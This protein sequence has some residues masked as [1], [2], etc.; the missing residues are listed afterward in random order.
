MPCAHLV[1]WQDCDARVI[2]ELYR[3]GPQYV[4]DLRDRPYFRNEFICPLRE[5]AGAH[6]SCVRRVVARNIVKLCC[7]A[8]AGATAYRASA[9]PRA[10]GGIWDRDAA[11]RRAVA[12]KLYVRD[13]ASGCLGGCSRKTISEN[14]ICALQFRSTAGPGD[15][16]SAV[17]QFAA[18]SSISAATR[19]NASRAS[20]RLP[21]MSRSVGKIVLSRCAVLHTGRAEIS[22]TSSTYATPSGKRSTRPAKD[23]RSG[24]S[25]APRLRWLSCAFVSTR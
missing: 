19:P 9:W 23:D 15:C 18:T 8:K 22:P 17:A 14:T 11:W 21:F 25:A 12:P 24:S 10:P 3:V 2:D 5:R 4:N 13:E 7:Q 6:Q 20:S 1:Q 16:A